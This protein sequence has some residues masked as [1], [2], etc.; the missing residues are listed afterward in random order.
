MIQEDPLPQAFSQLYNDKLII[1]KSSTFQNVTAVFSLHSNLCGNGKTK[2]PAEEQFTK[3]SLI[4]IRGL[5]HDA[6]N[7]ISS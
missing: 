5:K 4:G 3:V 1:I 7:Q 2:M 6:W